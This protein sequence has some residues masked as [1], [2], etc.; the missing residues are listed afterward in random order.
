[1]VDTDWPLI[2]N[3]IGLCTDA[4]LFCDDT[5]ALTVADLRTRAMRLTTEISAEYPDGLGLIIIDYI[6]LMESEDYLKSD[7]RNNQ[8]NSIT[9]GLK[10]LAKDLSVPVMALS[11]L[12]RNLESRP[13]KR[14]VMSDLRE[15]GG[16]E[17]D[18]DVITFIYRDEVYN[19]D[20]LDKGIA[21][22]IYAKQRNGELGTRRLGFEGQCT[23]FHNL[24]NPVVGGY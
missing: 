24:I 14:P 1:M 5:P 12:N 6:Q 8:I 15:S 22:I 9:R 13:N 23:R 21:E 2:S 17:Q 7:N 18:A 11:Q 3:A 4:P 19:H 10:R 20:T 16:I